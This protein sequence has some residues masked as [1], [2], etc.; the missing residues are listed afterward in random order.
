MLGLFVAQGTPDQE[1]FEPAG[2]IDPAL[3]VFRPCC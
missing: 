1:P 2:K 3:L